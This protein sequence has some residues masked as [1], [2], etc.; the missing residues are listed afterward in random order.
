MFWASFTSSDISKLSITLTDVVSP[1]KVYQLYN[2][3][4]TTDAIGSGIPSGKYNITGRDKISKSIVYLN[5]GV[6]G[7]GLDI[8]TLQTTRNVYTDLPV[9]I[10]APA[11][12]TVSSSGVTVQQTTVQVNLTDAAVAAFKSNSK[13][14]GKSA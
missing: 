2:L 1:Y 12:G 3:Q 4:L 6:D 13:S 7:K 10:A 8:S 11:T 14:S 5:A 9:T